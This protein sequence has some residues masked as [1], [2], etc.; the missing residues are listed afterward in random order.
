MN[1]QI[2]KNLIGDAL[3]ILLSVAVVLIISVF[4]R[5][6]IVN[7]ASMEETLHDGDYLIVYRQAYLNHSPERGDIVVIQSTLKDEKYEDK[8]IIKRVIGLPGDKIEIIDNN[9]YINDSQYQEAYIKGGITPIGKIP[10]EG[11]SIIIPEE[12]VYVLGD[13]RCN[14]NDSRST[15]VGLIAFDDIKG[16]AVIRLYPFTDIR[17]F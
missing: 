8:L 13:N 17:T 1:R 16:K 4:I 10:A 15:D 11:E 3:T 9:L 14:S 6:T 12:H 5:P 2:I 7:G